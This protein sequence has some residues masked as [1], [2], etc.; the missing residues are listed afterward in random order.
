[1]RT[2]FTVA[3]LAAISEAQYRPAQ[4]TY[5]SLFRNKPSAPTYQPPSAPARPTNH[6]SPP[7]PRPSN[8]HPHLHPSYPYPKP[9]PQPKPVHKHDNSI[10]H[11]NPWDQC[12]RD[13]A[14]TQNEVEHVANT[15][16]LDS[17]NSIMA[18]LMS[19]NMLVEDA[20]TAGT[21]IGTDLNTII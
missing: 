20:E 6:Y 7:A 13:I 21:D 9:V 14:T 18:S 11:E 4:M 12:K 16:E 15:C 17:I 8:F 10:I 19:Y 1:M 5:D 3:A 2:L